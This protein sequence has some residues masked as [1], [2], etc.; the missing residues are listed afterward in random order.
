MRG[1]PHLGWEVRHLLKTHQQV[2]IRQRVQ[3]ADMRQVAERAMHRQTPVTRPC[4]SAPAVVQIP[5]ERNIAR[6]L[7]NHRTR[8]PYIA[9]VWELELR[10]AG[11][12]ERF[13][14]IPAG[15]KHGFL[16]DFPIIASVQSPPNKDSF[17]SHLG[18]FKTILIKE[19]DKGRYL[20]PF[21][22]E[23]IEAA[24]GP[25]QTSPLSI[26]PK[27]GR[28]GKFR[29]IQ[30]F[31]FPLAP[32]AQFPNYSINAYIN[33]EDFP[34]A[35]GKFSV[36]FSLIAQLPPGSEAATRDVAEA[37]RTIPL[38][39]SQWPAAVVRISDTHGCIDTCLAPVRN[40]AI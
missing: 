19:I 36:I 5:M 16:I 38:H 21:P 33:A 10:C 25:F 31:S 3:Q 27:P 6:A 1:S 28:P 30:N 24:L 14:K 26:I 35:W 23:D 18:H 12:L 37:Y 15:I 9:D 11:L 34:T 2:V 17:N 4:T 20:G 40:G 13:H 8:T 39:E 22:L 7:R 32:S 29:L